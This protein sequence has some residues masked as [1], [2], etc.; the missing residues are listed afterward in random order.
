[1]KQT[2][3][4]ILLFVVCTSAQTKK[5]KIMP[6]FYTHTMKTI[7]GKEKSLADYKGKVLMVVNVASFCGNTPQYKQLQDVYEK[8]KEKGFAIAGFPANNFGQQEPGSDTDIK[9]FCEKNYG[10][11][12]DIF[13]KISV[14]GG[15]IH[16]LYKYLTTETNFNGDIEWNFAKFLVDKNGNVV[17]RF[18]D[19]KKADE[20]EVIT[21]I[22]ELLAQK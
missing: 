8:Y 2:V 22:E 6:P 19:K 5:E 21:K 12:F 14:K 15:D 20:K 4:A 10:V 9:T 16:P 18:G 11:T 3:V 7:D 17:A 13:S 1:M